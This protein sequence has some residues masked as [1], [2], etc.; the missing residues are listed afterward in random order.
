MLRI[1]LA[2]CSEFPDLDPDEFAFRDALVRLGVE[3]HSPVWSDDSVDWSIFDA[4]V[5]R[6]TWDYTDRI[7]EFLPWIAHVDSLT[8]LFNPAQVVRW[9]TDKHYLADLTRAGVSTVPT[10]FIEPGGDWSLDAFDE[11][12]VKPTVSC[13]SRDTMRY[14]AATSGIT[15]RAHVQRLLDDG[16]SVMV[17]PYI[18]SVDTIGES[19]LIYLDGAFSHS[20]RKGQMLHLDAEGERVAGL[21]VKEP[22]DPRKATDDELAVA[23]QVLDAIPGGRDQVLFARVDLIRDAEGTVMVLELELTEPSL[24]FRFS[25]SAGARLAA[26]VLNRL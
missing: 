9:N 11:F 20:I 4:V 23:E 22:I 6:N 18:S 2:S 26:G 24:F 1:A 19:A 10:Q 21:Y 12:V 17:Q 13:G 5:V 7:D 25:D 14:S 15:P 16:R 8:R 3:V